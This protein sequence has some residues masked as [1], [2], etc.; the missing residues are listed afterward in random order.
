ML[1]LSSLSTCSWAYYFSCSIKIAFL[2]VAFPTEARGPG[3]LVWDYPI[4]PL[5]FSFTHRDKIDL[6]AVLR[7]EYIITVSYI[8]YELSSSGSM[9]FVDSCHSRPENG[10]FSK[11]SV[12]YKV[13]D[14]SKWISPLF[15]LLPPR[16]QPGLPFPLNRIRLEPPLTSPCVFL[17]SW[18]KKVMRKLYS[19]NIVIIFCR[20]QTVYHYLNVTRR[21]KT[22]I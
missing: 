16:W 13:T 17:A 21:S 11:S 6:I 20:L 2:P 15:G 9:V 19:F 3:P 12:L 18:T 10:F 14:T 22:K 5:H 4:W 7:D 1:Q 8:L